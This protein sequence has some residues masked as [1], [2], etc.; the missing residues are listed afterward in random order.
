MTDDELNELTD[1]VLDKL[2]EKSATPHWHQYNT[3]MSLGELLK[4]MLPFKETEEEMLVSE[5]ARSVSYTHL[6]LP[7]ILR[8]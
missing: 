2:I 5:L 6:T 7:T 8:V 1:K 4:G 3:P